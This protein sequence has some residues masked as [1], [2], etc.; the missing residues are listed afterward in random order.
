MVKKLLTMTIL[1]LALTSCYNPLRNS[2]TDKVNASFEETFGDNVEQIKE[3][4]AEP[5]IEKPDFSVRRLDQPL[6]PRQISSYANPAEVLGVNGA[7]R[8]FSAEVDTSKLKL[9]YPEGTIPDGQT[10]MEGQ[11]FMNQSRF[12]DE[13]FEMKYN[14]DPQGPFVVRGA[15]FDA[16]QIPEQDF[17]GIGSSLKGKQYMLV[18]NRVLQRKIDKLRL[19]K[20]PYDDEIAEILVKEQSQ[21]K[22]DKRVNAIFNDDSAVIEARRLQKEKE[23]AER[24][25]ARQERIKNQDPIKKIIA[26]QVIEENKRK[27]SPNDPAQQ[28]QLQQDQQKAA[29][30]AQQNK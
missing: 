10:F 6:P 26:L 24:E 8:Y 2:N 11:R 30:A 18:G 12:S 19:N 14:T 22:K 9:T 1:I 5:T 27:N 16:I 7:S 3:M 28:Q 4:R 29:A 17:Y 15:E 23:E 13:I 20:A 25:L 21:R